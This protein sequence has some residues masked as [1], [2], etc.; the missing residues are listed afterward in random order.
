MG[1]YLRCEK[2][3]LDKIG[4]DRKCEGLAMRMITEFNLALLGK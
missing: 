4:L 1:W 2:D 3:K